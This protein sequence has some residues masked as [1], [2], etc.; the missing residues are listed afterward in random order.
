MPLPSTSSP[1]VSVNRPVPSTI[2]SVAS[3]FAEASLTARRR[4]VQFRTPCACGVHGVAVLSAVEVTRKVAP[5]AGAAGNR[6]RAR[7]ATIA[8]RRMRA[9]VTAA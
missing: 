7:T 4:L 8:E 9:T 2:S 5:E 3:A 1:P 6:H